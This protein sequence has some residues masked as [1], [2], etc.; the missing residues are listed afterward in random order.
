[1]Q[2]KVVVVDWEAPPSVRRWV[3]RLGIPLAVVAGA[4]AVAYASVPIVFTSHSPLTAGDLNADF[5]NLDSR[6]GAIEDS[7]AQYAAQAGHALTADNATQATG[8]APGTF[9][10]HGDLTTAGNASIGGTLSVGIHASTSCTFDTVN[11]FTD[12]AC[13]ANEV[14]IGGG[15]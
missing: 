2:I 3:I 1:M 11:G 14:A 7:G 10:V 9:A 8:G 15:A 12:C 13:A 5:Y 4:G 6:L